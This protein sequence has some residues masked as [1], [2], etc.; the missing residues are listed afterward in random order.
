[1]L[2]L[3][4]EEL[5]TRGDAHGVELSVRREILFNFTKLC[6]VPLPQKHIKL[7]R[8]DGEGGRAGA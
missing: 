3:K 2:E 7:K 8:G 5:L 4:E 6:S 1:M